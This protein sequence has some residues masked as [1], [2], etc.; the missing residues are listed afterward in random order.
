MQSVLYCAKCGMLQLLPN[1]YYH[2]IAGA[3]KILA[4][5]HDKHYKCW[6][7][8][9]E[10]IGLEHQGGHSPYQH[11]QVIAINRFLDRRGWQLCL[12]VRADHVPWKGQATAHYA[13]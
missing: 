13:G 8:R 3:V 5:L 12:D 7:W 9:Y 4:S 11:I 6:S 1:E 2:T 10:L